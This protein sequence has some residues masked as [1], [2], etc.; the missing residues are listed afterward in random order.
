MI[1]KK[2]P[3]SIDIQPAHMTNTQIKIVNCHDKTG[4]ELYRIIYTTGLGW[5]NGEV[6]RNLWS[7]PAME[8]PMRQTNVMS[9]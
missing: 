1:R 8:T 9:N 5:W 7:S 6:G 2:Q 3:T 4:K